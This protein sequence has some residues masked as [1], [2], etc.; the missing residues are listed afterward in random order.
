M[1]KSLVVILCGLLFL[2][3]IGCDIEFEDTSSQNSSNDSKISSGI[4][5]SSD[6]QSTD[7][8]SSETV[9]SSSSKESSL[10]KVASSS[11]VQTT[12]ESSSKEESSKQTEVK[13]KSVY[14]TPTGKRYHLDPDCGGKNSSPST[15]SAAERRGLTPCKKCAQ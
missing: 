2:S 7:V 4:I 13:E 8:S 3:I 12:I 11:K 10:S 14:V 1:K 6:K 15:L 5:Y 9:E